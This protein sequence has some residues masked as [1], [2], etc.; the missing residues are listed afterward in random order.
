MPRSLTVEYRVSE[1]P[2]ALSHAAAQHFLDCARTAVG[3]RGT[4]R[5]AISGGS[6]PK[7]TFKLL[8]DPAQPY[9]AQMPWEK[10][11]IFWV[12]ERCLPPDQ[13]DSNYHMT[14]ENLLDHVPIPADQIHRIYGELDPEEAAAKYE[15]ELRNHFRLEGAQGPVFDM[16]ALGMGDDGHTASLF[17]HTEA[18]HEMMR[19]AVANHV[20]QQK[21]SWRITL[22]WPVIVEARDVFFLIAGKDKADSL[23]RVL[24]GAYDPE[25]LPSQLIQPRSGKLLM[26]LDRQAADLLPAPDARGIGMLEIQR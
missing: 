9:R 7:A 1:D 5:L 20:P 4:A 23:H 25:A 8:A 13:P 22:T 15:S 16:L 14:R 12:D 18:L 2:V 24:Q 26:L 19:L 6:T 21:H 17:P 3:S 11:E 10:L